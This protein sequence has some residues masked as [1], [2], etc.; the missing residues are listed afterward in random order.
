MPLPTKTKAPTART[1]RAGTTKM[2]ASYHKPSQVSSIGFVA[3]Y[4]LRRFK[5]Q[6]MAQDCP[7]APRLVEAVD[8]LLDHE[9]GRS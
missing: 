4:A 9:E 8:I 5:T 6:L 3:V 1:V 2:Q 7:E